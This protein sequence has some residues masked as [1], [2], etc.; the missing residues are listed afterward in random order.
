MMA[1]PSF[2][3]SVGDF[4][5]SISLVRQLIRALNDSAGSRTAYRK[6]ISELLNLDEALNGIRALQLASPAQALQKTALES[7]VSQC[8]DSIER[9]L[10]KTAKYKDSLGVDACAQSSSTSRWRANFHKI[11]WAL[12]EESAVDA[13]R[14]EIHSHTTSLNLVLSTIHLLVLYYNLWTSSVFAVP[15]QGIAWTRRLIYFAAERPPDHSWTPSRTVSTLLQTQEKREARL[16]RS[17][18]RAITYSLLRG[19]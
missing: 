12:C 3:F 10:E 19:T 7:V 16:L 4:I 18:N 15:S 13:L 11:Q 1:S 17:P 9:F 2:G 6:L 8:Q 5:A 14:T